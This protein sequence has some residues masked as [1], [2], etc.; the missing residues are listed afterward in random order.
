M[1]ALARHMLHKT[2]KYMSQGLD[3]AGSKKSTSDTSVHVT[4]LS[5]VACEFLPGLFQPR[6][7]YTIHFIVIVAH[8]L[9]IIT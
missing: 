1:D 9:Y 4:A 8:I 5:A 3:P 2:H 7:S 6:T